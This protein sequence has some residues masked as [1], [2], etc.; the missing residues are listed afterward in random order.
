MRKALLVVGALVL[1]VLF[2]GADT[3]DSVAAPNVTMWTAR[4]PGTGAATESANFYPTLTPRSLGRFGHVAFQ[5]DTISCGWDTAGSGGSTGVVAAVVQTSD[6]GVI[7]SCT[8]GA[9]TA[10]AGTTNT[11]DCGAVKYLNAT[12]WDAGQFALRLTSGTDCAANPQNVWCSTLL[13]R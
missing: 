7:C 11:C 9:C 3:L 1:G 10:T 8:V 6:A 5:F 13:F 4:Q 2:M 12:G